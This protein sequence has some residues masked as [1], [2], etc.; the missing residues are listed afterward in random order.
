MHDEQSKMRELQTM[1]DDKELDTALFNYSVYV[2]RSL[3]LKRKA[4]SK[5]KTV[6]ELETGS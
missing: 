2:T 3:S 6:T 1:E 4:Q 5:A